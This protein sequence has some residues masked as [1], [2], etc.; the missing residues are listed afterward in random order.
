MG[1]KTN[2]NILRMGVTKK[3]FCRYLEKKTSEIA[4]YDFNNIEIEK[5]TNKFFKDNKFYINKFK[6]NY[7]HEG[8]LQIFV[9]YYSA[10][11]KLKNNF[12]N[13]DEDD[14]NPQ[15]SKLEKRIEN[16]HNSVYSLFNA[17]KSLKNSK[18]KTKKVIYLKKIIKKN[19]NTSLKNSNELLFE[20]YNNIKEIESN[21]L[22]NL[23]CES[24]T[25]FLNKKINIFVTFQ[26]LNK[27]LKKKTDKKKLEFFKKCLI[28][29]YRYRESDF[30]EEGI[31]TLF[32]CSQQANSANLLAN[33]IATQLKKLK[34]HNFFLRFVKKCLT[35][36]YS[37]K[38][39][40]LKGVK[41]KVKGRLNRRPRARHRFFKIG[42]E[43]PLLSIGSNIYYSER[44]AFTPNGTM[45]IKVWTL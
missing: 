6:I 24:L 3:S 23:F 28:K 45:G 21:Y 17:F 13:D 2:P 16:K 12:V 42:K 41:I 35:V 27:N 44:V 7:S 38:Y 4:L 43:L 26:Q 11:F 9:S 18:K 22:I 5:F 33:F 37:S 34:R 36:F 8:I 25:K 29:F 39:S 10:K 40:K 20:K 32:I 31:N 19:Y 15:T 14:S 30:F 1:Q